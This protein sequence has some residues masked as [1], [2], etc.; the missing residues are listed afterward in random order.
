MKLVNLIIR[1]MSTKEWK[2]WVEHFVTLKEIEDPEKEIRAAVQDFLNSGTEEA[3]QAISFACG[4][5]N[6]GDAISSV[7]NEFFFNRGLYYSGIPESVDIN[8]EHDEIL[9][10]ETSGND[11]EEKAKRHEE[12]V[13]PECGSTNLEYGE[14][15]IKDTSYG[16]QWAC[17]DC[18]AEGT[19]WYA[20]SFSEHSVRKHG[21]V[22][23]GAATD[24]KED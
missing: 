16:Y 19:E 24:S 13:C 4:Y 14:S 10:D 22:L 8:V 2:V 1:D 20:L 17:D 3:K 5:F 21:C 9:C 18:G 11:L 15:G 6:W 12:G 7:P 23:S